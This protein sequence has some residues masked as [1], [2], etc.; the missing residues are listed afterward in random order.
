ME[1]KEVIRL[2]KERTNIRVGKRLIQGTCGVG[3]VLETRLYGF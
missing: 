1:H 3:E 2:F